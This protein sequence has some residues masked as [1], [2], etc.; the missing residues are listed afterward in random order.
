MKK[1]IICLFSLILVFCSCDR[2]ITSNEPSTEATIEL[3]TDSSTDTTIELATESSDDTEIAQI[4][5]D[6]DENSAT[7]T[8]IGEGK[9]DVDEYSTLYF[10]I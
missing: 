7:L 3:T 10:D 2:Q 5:Y 8:I 4:S 1:K 9:M 6:Y